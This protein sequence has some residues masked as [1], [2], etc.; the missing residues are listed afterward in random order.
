MYISAT[1]YNKKLNNNSRTFK[2]RAH[3]FKRWLSVVKC[4]KVNTLTPF[5]T[6]VLVYIF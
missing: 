5:P 4:Y 2:L 3:W 1:A 6:P